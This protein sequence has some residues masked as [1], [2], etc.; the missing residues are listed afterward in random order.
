MQ[1]FENCIWN[2]LIVSAPVS[3]R[4]KEEEKKK[5]LGQKEK[6]PQTW[7]FDGMANLPSHHWDAWKVRHLTLVQIN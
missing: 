3:Y 7:Q 6:A 5:K 4:E 1:L 2:K